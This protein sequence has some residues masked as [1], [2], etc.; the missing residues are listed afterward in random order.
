V[1]FAT[2]L[3]VSRLILVVPVAAL[4]LRGNN[5]GFAFGLFCVAAVTDYFDGFVARR[6]DQVTALGARLDAFVDKVLVYVAVIVLY[7]RGAY[8]LPVVVLALSRDVMVEFLRQKSA[9]ARSVIPANRWG[10]LKFILQ[11]ASIAVALAPGIGLGVASYFAANAL[12][13]LATVVSLPGFAAV[14]K[15]AQARPLA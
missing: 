3:T 8:L 10:K 13:L 12:L 4:V 5:N 11:C 14:L 6:F 15:A 2:L 1:T 9:V 7:A